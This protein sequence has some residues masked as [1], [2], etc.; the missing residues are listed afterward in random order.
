MYRPEN[1]GRRLRGDGDRP[2]KKLGGGNRGAFIP[3]TFRK[4][5]AN[6]HFKKD[7]YETE[8]RLGHACDR[9]QHTSIILFP[10]TMTLH[11]KNCIV[12]LNKFSLVNI[13]Q[14]TS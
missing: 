3:P 13:V 6:L 5:V 8:I 9:D 4:C 12:T 1:Q 10:Y 14:L 2:L 7:K 11:C